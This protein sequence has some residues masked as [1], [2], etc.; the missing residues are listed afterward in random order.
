MNSEQ[1]L[2]R[3]LNCDLKQGS[4]KIL[5]RNIC[6]VR[7]GQ[8]PPVILVHGGNLGWGQWYKTIPELAK[9]HTVYAPDLPGGGRSD[10]VDFFRVDLEKDMVETL[11]IFIKNLGLE[12]A[13]IV[14]SSAG[15]WMAV[16]VAL[17]PALETR[18]LVISD[19][20]GFSRTRTMPDRIM[21]TEFLAKFLS[22]TVLKPDPENKSLRKFLSS[23]FFDPQTPISQEF[24]EY[25]LETMTRTHNLHFISRLA[26]RR[27]SQETFLGDD[28]ARIRP[29]TLII[30]GAEDSFLPL[31]Y[32]APSF[33]KIPEKEIRIFERAGHIPPLEQP[34]RFHA[35]VSEFLSS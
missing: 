5:G 22:R 23:V 28:L 24:Y 33:S 1:H 6:Y 19:S 12:G 34:Q 8:G 29:R 11:K 10:P 16:R 32:S 20:V 27:G 4:E 30:W 35:V 2:I 7:A 26:S 13:D 14:G 21:G 31:K 18:R 3:S 15:G 25:F 9:H 17:D